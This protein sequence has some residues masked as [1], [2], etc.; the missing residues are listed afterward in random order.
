MITPKQAEKVKELFQQ[1]IPQTTIAK[2]TH[3]SRN[4]VSEIVKEKKNSKVNNKEFRQ[5]EE[6]EADSEIIKLKKEL[7][8]AELKRQIGEQKQPFEIEKKLKELEEKIKELDE[9]VDALCSEVLC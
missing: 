6:I 1:G 4:K 7:R 8:K 5:E 2:Q 3:I 9:W